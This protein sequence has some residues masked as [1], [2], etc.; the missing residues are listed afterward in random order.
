[1]IKFILPDGAALEFGANNDEKSF[2]ELISSVD[3][4]ILNSVVAAKVNGEVKDLRDVPADGCE[5]ELVGLDSK[6]A[7]HVLRHTATHIMAEAVKH[8]FPD[9]KLTIGP[10]T[11]T[12]FFYDFDCPPFTKENLEAIEK[13]MKKVNG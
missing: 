2:I 10:S 7:L 3:P 9:A 5:A 13:E 1:M 12:G 4:K 6:E 8:L 11:D